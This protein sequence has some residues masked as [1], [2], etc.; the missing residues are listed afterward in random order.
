MALPLATAALGQVVGT[1]SVGI[2]ATIKYPAALV[3]VSSASGGVCGFLFFVVEFGLR[4]SVAVGAVGSWPVE[5]HNSPR[6]WLAAPGI[7]GSPKQRGPVLLRV[8][9]PDRRDVRNRPSGALLVR[10]GFP[11]TGSL[12]LAFTVANALVAAAFAWSLQVPSGWGSPPRPRVAWYY[13][14]IRY[15]CRLKPLRDC[16]AG[17]DLSSASPIRHKLLAA[18]PC[19]TRPAPCQDS[20]FSERT[21]ASPCKIPQRT[22]LTTGK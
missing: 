6:F 3:T 1:C 10:Q 16:R 12:C 4:L 2:L 13:C 17:T 19:P 21:R 9:Q 20:G 8:Q 7:P 5:H 22:G 11:G 15:P 18:A 14:T